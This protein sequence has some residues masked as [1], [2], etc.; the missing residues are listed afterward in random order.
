MQPRTLFELACG[1]AILCACPAPAAEG[2]QQ[3]VEQYLESR[4]AS[5]AAV[6]PVTDES[7]ARV[8]PD[9]TFFGVIFRR[10]PIA[11]QCPETGDLKCANLF[12][13][14]QGQVDFV[15][16]TAD[17]EFFF[18][19]EAKLAATEQSAG[20]LAAA[21]LRFSQELKQDLFYSFAAPQITYSPQQD[22][23]RVRAQSNVAAGGEGKIE[24]LITLGTAGSLLSIQERGALRQGIRPVCQATKLLDPDALV[25][26]IVEQ[27]LLVMG[28]A[29]KPYLDHIRSSASP[30]LTKAIDRIWLRIRV[31]G[32]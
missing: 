8:F 18:K 7:I 6:R 2:D 21:W 12:F 25:R 23:V 9:Y 17:L 24:V 1:I 11:V 28:R 22:M 16:T 26:K 32:R 29:A 5:H 19:T 14:K 10:F 31:E 15:N 27:D 30:D 13:V 3:L 4:A 20:D